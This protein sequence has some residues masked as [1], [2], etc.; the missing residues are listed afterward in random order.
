MT[1]KLFK[2]KKIEGSGRALDTSTVHIPQVDGQTASDYP[3]GS[4]KKSSSGVYTNTTKFFFSN[5]KT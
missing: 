4:R 1:G 5:E 3:S 2:K